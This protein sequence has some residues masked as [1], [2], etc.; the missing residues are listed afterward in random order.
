MRIATE[1][2]ESQLRSL[3]KDKNEV[4]ELKGI[5]GNPGKATGKARI[6][7]K[8]SE[9]HKFQKGDILV[10]AFT[11]PDFTPVIK[12]AAAIVT[13]FGGIT[14]HASI[15]S[16][17]MNIPCVVGTEHATTSIKDGD[18]IEVDANK[19]VVRKVK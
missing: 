14:S 10:T 2:E 5:C 8:T 17:E 16:R 9:F 6:I 19:C 1:D 13:D 18:I 7:V 3:F 15:I 12:K 11:T 4:H